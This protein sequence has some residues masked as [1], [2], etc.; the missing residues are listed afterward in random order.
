MIRIPDMK[1]FDMRTIF[2]MIAVLALILT[3]NPAGVASADPANVG[4]VKIIEYGVNAVG[5]DTS[6]NRN[7]EFVRIMNVGEAA[8][9]IEGWTLHDTYQNA[10]GDYGNRFTFRGATLPAGSPMKDAVTGDFVL[11]A[12]DQAYVYNGSGADTTPTNHTAAIYRNFKHMWNNAGDTIYVRDGDG[13]VIHWVTYT[14]YRTR[15]G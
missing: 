5:K 4:K 15:V 14:P 7:A 8:V 3:F 1:G 11:A 10:A 6:G 9:V 13:T 2:T 12:G